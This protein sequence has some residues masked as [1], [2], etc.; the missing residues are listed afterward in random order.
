MS[1]IYHPLKQFFNDYENNQE[2]VIIIIAVF[3]TPW[4]M[5]T[6]ASDNERY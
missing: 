3:F 1:L 4:P 2:G 6:R 5:M